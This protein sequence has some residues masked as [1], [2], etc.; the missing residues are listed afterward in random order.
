MEDKVSKTTRG[1]KMWREEG[2]REKGRGGGRG[3]KGEGLGREKG[4]RS[5]GKKEWEWSTCYY[6]SQVKYVLCKV[7][8]YLLSSYIPMQADNF[9][10]IQTP[11]QCQKADVAPFTH[12]GRSFR[13]SDFINH[14]PSRFPESKH[15]R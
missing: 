4:R 9:G 11:N 13:L 5:K 1:V 7:Q 14:C 3:R 8:Y 12:L 2:V 6:P 15:S 10:N